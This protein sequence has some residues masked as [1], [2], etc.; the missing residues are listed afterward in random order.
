[1]NGPTV[2]QTTCAPEKRLV[3][4]STSWLTST[5][6]YCAVSMPGILSTTAWTFLPSRPAAMNG[7]WYSRR[8]SQISRP[9]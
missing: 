5:T 6:S 4:D 3:S 8:Y 7:T 9:V 1:M 2:E